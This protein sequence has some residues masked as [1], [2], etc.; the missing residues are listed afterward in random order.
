MIISMFVSCVPA[1]KLSDVGLGTR[2]RYSLLVDKDVKQTNSDGQ[3]PD[4]S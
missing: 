3:P 2:P 1:R 4:L